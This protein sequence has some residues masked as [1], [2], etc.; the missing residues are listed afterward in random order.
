[1]V[2]KYC[3][4]YHDKNKAGVP[5]THIVYKKSL[6]EVEKVMEEK[7]QVT[8]FPMSGVCYS[9]PCVTVSEGAIVL[10]R[11][12]SKDEMYNLREALFLMRDA[13]KDGM[14]RIMK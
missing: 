8:V 6:P 14:V 9:R 5:C 3:V 2:L 11:L 12:E 13:T 10:Y 7:N 4:V 1:M